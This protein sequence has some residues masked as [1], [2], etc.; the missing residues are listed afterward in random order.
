MIDTASYDAQLQQAV[1]N[2]AK[3][4]ANLTNAQQTFQRV[5]NLQKQNVASA[6]DFDL[7]KAQLQQWDAELKAAQGLE[8]IARLNVSRS[9]VVAPFDGGIA[10][11]VVGR[12]D[13]VK[14]GSL[15]EREPPHA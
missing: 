7:A 2:T 3:A 13:F 4:S 12:G 8:G 14:I 1:G 10:R 5:E 6:S 11:R 15:S 9:R